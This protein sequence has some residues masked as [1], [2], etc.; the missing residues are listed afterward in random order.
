MTNKEAIKEI[1]NTAKLAGLTF[2]THPRLRINGGAAYQFVTRNV[3]EVVMDNCTLSSSYENCVSGFISSW[4]GTSFVG[5][6]CY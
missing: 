3:G 2:R 4:N 5:V 1:R 6:N